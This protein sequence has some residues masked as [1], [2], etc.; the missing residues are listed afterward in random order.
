MPDNLQSP[1]E[2]SSRSVAE[3]SRCADATRA[4]FQALEAQ[5]DEHIRLIQTFVRI[6]STLGRE[7][8]AQVWLARE[9]RRLGLLVDMFDC[10]PAE[11]SSLPGWA[12]VDW[13][14]EDR[15]NI[16][17]LRPTVGSGRSLILS[18]HVDTVEADPV[19]LW[20][21]DP[22]GGEIVGNR[23]YG[24]GAQDDKA[25][26]IAMLMIVQA[27]QDA[28]VRLSGDLILQSII[29]EEI[30]GNGTLACMSR[31]YDADGA[32]M[33]DGTGLGRAI[34]AHPGQ[35]A[36]RITCY[37]R[38]V[39]WGNAHRGVNAIEK[40]WLIIQALRQLEAR[41]NEHIHPQ[42]AHLEHPLNL[43]LWGI[44]GG[45]WLGTVAARC[46]VEGALSFVPPD[47][48]NSIRREIEETLTSAAA[49]DPWL[50][51]HQPVL[52]F[53]ALNLDP[54]FTTPDHDLWRCLDKA[55]EGVTGHPLTPSTITGWCDIRHFSLNQPTPACLFGPG[56]GG[57]AHS[58]DEWLDLDDIRPVTKILAEFVIKW[59]GVA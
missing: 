53:H 59:C 5:H 33:V 40:A 48:L 3:D 35:I 38:P 1:R 52:R 44:H 16:V 9:M 54:L 19:E 15:P 32:I 47:T 27:L 45:E 41:K 50:K 13:S 39:P 4:V 37:G 20:S 21:R 57:G 8:P 29:E 24:R 11:L 6:R 56:G 18:A 26:A 23:I 36:F 12:T 14:Y 42:W 49:A 43:N 25:G 22:W 46:T 10:D 51:E 7:K 58:T 28:G 55:H 31:G 30:T 2:Q 17:A 34:V